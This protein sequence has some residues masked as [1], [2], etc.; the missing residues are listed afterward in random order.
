MRELDRMIMSHVA[1]PTCSG[2]SP[3]RLSNFKFQLH[4]LTLSERV[5]AI[6]LLF[7]PLS[8][9]SDPLWP[10]C[11]HFLISNGK[12]YKAKHAKQHA[13]KQGAEKRA[14]A[15]SGSKRG[16]AWGIRFPENEKLLPWLPLVI[17][18][19]FLP[20]FSLNLSRKRE[21]AQAQPPKTKD[22]TRTDRERD[23]NNPPPPHVAP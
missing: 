5:N 4:T 18:P 15:A 14:K 7:L 1:R 23:P 2:D 10:L 8:L 21:R 13:T 11:N 22:R 17:R 19:P 3:L 12:T 20:S 9:F 6:T 16:K